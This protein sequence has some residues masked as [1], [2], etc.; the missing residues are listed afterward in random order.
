MFKL[1]FICCFTIFGFMS[2]AQSISFTYVNA[3][4]GSFCGSSTI[5]FTPV[6]TGNPIGFTWYFGNGQT[7]NSSIPSISFTTG[8]YLV[9]L[10]AV[11]QNVAIE[12]TQTITVAPAL[13]STLTANKNSICKPDTIKLKAT[14]SAPNSLYT[15]SFGDGS[16]SISSTLD[17]V[18]HFYTGYGIFRAKV[19][20]TNLAGCV[21]SSIYEIEVKR[22]ELFGYANPLSGCKPLNVNFTANASLPTGV[23]ANNF[24]WYFGDNSTPQS[25]GN[26]TNQ[27]PYT[28]TG[29]FF[30]KVLI[31]TSNGCADTFKFFE[32]SVG[33][34]PTNLVAYADKPTYC[35]NEKAV[36]HAFAP[37]AN[38]YKYQYGD[39]ITETLIDTL[40]YHK[41]ATLGLKTVTIT[42]YFNNCPGTP[43]TFTINIVGVIA[44]YQYANTCSNK[45]RFTL[46]NV[47]Q[48][49]LSF[50]Q[51]TFGDTSPTTLSINAIHNY[52]LSGEFTT[53]LIVG[54]NITGCKDTVQYILYTASPTLQNPDTFLCKKASTTYTI[55]NNYTNPFLSNNWVV[56][57][58]NTT[59]SSNTQMVYAYTFGNF[60]DIVILDNGS[61]YCL[62]TIKLN[63]PISVRGPIVGFNSNPL[64]CTNNN[65]IVTNTSYPYSSFDTIKNWR[66][67]FGNSAQ[68]DN[69]Y[70]PIPFQYTEEGNY[71]IQLIA[72]D[73]KGCTDSAF[74]TVLVRESPFLRIFPR[75]D[76]ICLGKKVTLTAYHTD[77][78]V[79]SPANL[80]TCAT[81]D[82]TDATPVNNITKI[83]AIAS[84]AVGCTLM[85]STTI[86][87]YSPFTA[88]ANSSPVFAC[89]ND[90]VSIGV[91]PFNKKIIWSPIDALTNSNLN[92][93]IATI[94]NDTITYTALLT[95]SLNCYSSSTGVKVIAYPSP[96]VNAGPDRILAA[97]S[98]FTIT[99]VYGNSVTKYEWSPSGN[100]SCT[101]CPYPMGIA[102]SLRYYTIKTKNN[103]GCSASDDIKIGIECLYANLFMA[104][105]FNPDNITTNNY[106]FPQTRGIKTI[107]SF[108]IYNRYGEIV[109]ETNN[110]IPNLRRSGWD[111][112]YK[113]IPQPANGYV[114]TLTA[115]CEL[116]EIFNKSGSFLLLR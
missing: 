95:D 60:N 87:V 42:P 10:V 7:S 101:N 73:K 30:P 49:N 63:H 68:E 91:K 29:T 15:F 106:Y 27:Y 92:Q 31:N 26:G 53:Q 79:W 80:V 5:N 6:Y 70:Q 89:K 99:P 67:S 22:L 64:G 38:S 116:G 47:S 23:F 111:G 17:T 41:Y 104:S 36:L 58:S 113:G 44:D 97:N 48:G 59:S 21:D 14:S 8:S 52:P 65:F 37:L 107:N 90:T 102:D 33:M 9:K 43:I 4:S 19:K 66:W 20:V 77:T 51:W 81:C 46:T 94:K 71:N 93:T 11:F 34:P 25:T 57:G 24:I 13:T 86:I 75:G 98:P 55:L 85:D 88:T 103:F 16:Q 69:N 56:V 110:A 109:F 35:G 3:N 112:K 78:L 40:V 1:I 62:D 74:G 108:K 32:V 83:F 2:S 50:T 96:T 82:T 115:T 39:G 84:N 28:D 72:K 105:A 18:S 61:Q 12:T 114:Y 54:D 100:L 45:K 76:K